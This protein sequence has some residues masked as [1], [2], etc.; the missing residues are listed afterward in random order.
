M[1]FEK[2]RLENWGP[3]K[4]FHEISVSTSDGA[5]VVL[6][7]GE[8]G[9][10]KTSFAKALRWCLYGANSNVTPGQYA[11]WGRVLDGEDFPVGVT[12]WF[13]INSGVDGD[14]G[15]Q[16][17]YE[18]SRNFIAHPDG[19]TTLGVAVK[20][21]EP[22]LRQTSGGFIEQGQISRFIQKHLPLEMA[23]FFLFD[24][25]E[26]NS[27][28]T[29]L[30]GGGVSSSV[31]DGIESVMGIPALKELDALIRD[32][33]KVIDK[34]QGKVQGHMAAQNALEVAKQNLERK[35]AELHDTKRDLKETEDRVA[36]LTAD[37]AKYK[38]FADKFA[39]KDIH[40]KIKAEAENEARQAQND[41]KE[42]LHDFWWIPLVEQI[43]KSQERENRQRIQKSKRI[44]LN[45][46]LAQLQSI[47]ESGTCLTCGQPAGLSDSDRAEMIQ[48]REKLLDSADETVE[49]QG[50]VERFRNPDV[51]HV[52]AQT[53]LL[54]ERRAMSKAREIKDE[55]AILEMQLAEVD[56]ERTRGILPMLLNAQKYEGGLKE[57][58]E[59]L[60]KEVLDL[61]AVEAEKRKAWVKLGD[62]PESQE[63]LS[64][65]L[66]QLQDIIGKVR[67]SFR[68]KVR[69]EVA[70][71]A[72]SHYVTMMEN[73]DLVGI[74][75]TPDFRVR[76]IS[77]VFEEP[78]PFSSYGQ[79]LI[80]VYAFIGALIDVSGND[81]SWLIDTVGSRL[82]RDKMRAV[83]EWLSTRNRQVIAMPHSGELTK[84]DAMVFVGSRVSRRYE[85]IDASSRD[86]DSRIMEIFT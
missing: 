43:K 3:F 22:Q 37:L 53:L 46:R 39:Q 31:R 44:E 69:E 73:E 55:L 68:D 82:D 59:S 65:A 28:K 42:H 77:R 51:Q 1:R 75:I 9:K 35:T 79:S 24:G 6:I 5:P 32:Q 14:H 16:Q 56:E 25:E 49:P 26:L 62:L 54:E 45:S 30:E 41:I 7:F 15:E 27:L 20:N 18:L 61:R 74:D 72:S 78:K 67:E 2:I 70:L 8:N 58:V 33:Q 71:V 76:P 57:R 36:S 84:D 10:G 63:N 50:F 85:I 17:S 60:E 4:G 40:L 47:L 19:R 11:N 29:E 48:I 38:E 83:W 21:E 81:G 34:S 13:S 12:V 23:R 80:A 66:Q 52:L 64:K 86:T